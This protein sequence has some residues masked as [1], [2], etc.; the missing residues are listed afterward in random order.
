[1]PESM[2]CSQNLAIANVKHSGPCI[3]ELSVLCLSASRLP[4]TYLRLQRYT[5]TEEAFISQFPE[6]LQVES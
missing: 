5:G 6:L 2:D 4:R 1:M 3:P